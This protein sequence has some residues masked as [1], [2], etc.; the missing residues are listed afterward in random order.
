[1]RLSAQLIPTT[2]EGAVP[3]AVSASLSDRD[4]VCPAIAGSAWVEGDALKL[5]LPRGDL[6]LRAPK[7]LLRRVF[8]RCDGMTPWSE[9]IA[10]TPPKQRDEFSRF[11]EF[12]F[13]QGALVDAIH[14]TV[15]AS[16]LAWQATPMGLEAPAELTDEIGLRLRGEAKAAGLPSAT[17]IAATP[18]EALLR[19]RSTA[20]TFDDKP[21]SERTLHALLWAAGGIVSE[22]HP[23][24]S[25]PL[26]QRVVPS[27]GAMYLVRWMLV[28]QQPVGDH[29]PGVYAKVSA[30]P[31]GSRL[32]SRRYAPLPS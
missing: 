13:E 19:E 32:E 14:L 10:A 25:N 5:R 28:L 30:L 2:A 22:R 11:L 16:V 8:D 12:L 21:L 3:D 31:L 7:R 9:L 23:R 24:P 6:Q 20:R 15:S 27:A 18:L 26:P 1:M 17:N 29:A 4:R